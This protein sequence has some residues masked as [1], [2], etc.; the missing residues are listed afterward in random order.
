MDP[1]LVV[2]PQIEHVGARQQGEHGPFEKEPGAAEHG[3][4]RHRA[5][6]LQQF[7]DVIAQLGTESHEG[8]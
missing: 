7:E 1:G 3:A 4:R 5:E 6:R 8:P 2:G